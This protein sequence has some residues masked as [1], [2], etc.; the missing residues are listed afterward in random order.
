MENSQTNVFLT[1]IEYLKGIGPRRA[2]TLKNEL[3][4]YNAGDLLTFYPFRYVDKSRFY[5]VSQLRQVQDVD[6]QVVGRLGRV[7]EV[8]QGLKVVRMTATLSDGTGVMQLVWFKG[9]SWIKRNLKEGENYVV[10]GRVSIFAG[11]VSMAHPEMETQLQYEA[12]PMG[13]LVPV[14]SSTE[15]TQKAG[16]TQRLISTAIH[17]FLEQ[18]DSHIH[19]TLSRDV[20]KENNLMGRR[21]AIRNIHF[22]VDNESLSRARYR[23]KFEELFYMQMAMVRKKIARANRFTGYKFAVVGRLFNEFYAHHLSFELTGAQKRVIKE[24]RRDV[25]TGAQMNRLVQGDVG[26]GKTVVALMAMLMALDNGYQ[27]CMMAPTEILATQHY[28]SIS[29]MVEGMGV[30]VELL[31]GSTRTAHRREILEG[32]QNGDI[33]IVVGTHALIEDTVIFKNLAL[34]VI[35][36]QHRFGVE[37]RSRLWGKSVFPPHVLVMTATPIPRTLAMTVYG[38]LDVSVI[39]ELPAGRR[40]VQTLHRYEQ[41]R[42][43]VLGFMKGQIDK[44]RQVYVVYPLIEESEGMDYKNLIDGYTDLDEYFERPAYNVEVVHGRMKAE[45]KDAIIERFSSGVAN[46]LVSTTVIEVGVDIPNATVMVIES[47]ERFGL[48]QLHQLRGRVG[49]GREQSYCILMTGDKLSDDARRRMEAMVSTTDG[50]KIAELDMKLRGWGDMMGVRQ[51][52]MADLKIADLTRD[53]DIMA[54]SREAAQKILFNDP[55]LREPHHEILRRSYDVVMKG[56]ALW[57][58]IS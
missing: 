31:T 40:P 6:V 36:E 30:R 52:G 53:A 13:T 14:Y 9:F 38:D 44:G 50:F 26:S 4:I 32:L 55:D 42:L 29:R 43:G 23:M 19:E 35:D 45:E 28:N 51:S 27:A 18:W 48:A 16:I 21:E 8:K 24:I 37:Q 17:S 56:K 2:M 47:A 10:Y 22:P 58:Y 57:G 12:S 41:S 39:D 5:T 3:G 25:N 46:I 54:A 11:R 7:E 33:H 1:P 34:A 15:K 20:L 49:R